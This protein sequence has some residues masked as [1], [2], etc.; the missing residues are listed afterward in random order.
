M[1]RL[2]WAASK[3]FGRSARAFFWPL[4]DAQEQAGAAR[5]R[6][7]TPAARAASWALIGFIRNTKRLRFKT[8]RTARQTVVGFADASGSHMGGCLLSDKGGAFFSEPVGPRLAAR[9][10]RHAKNTINVAESLAA[11]TWLQTFS[12]GLLNGD[13][14]LFLDSES[15]E[16]SLLSG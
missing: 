8:S 10:P 16:G 11:L 2:E 12:S 9:L 7:L 1:G 4:R 14:I 6:V 5:S 15:A 13:V 3:Y